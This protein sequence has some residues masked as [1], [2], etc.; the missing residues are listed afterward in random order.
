M[1][2][3][4]RPRDG[5]DAKAQKVKAFTAVSLEWLKRDIIKD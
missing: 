1:F 4:P 5:E 3:A 2:S